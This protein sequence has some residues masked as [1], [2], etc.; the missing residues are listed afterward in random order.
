MD[1]PNRTA[2]PLEDPAER[3]RVIRDA[4]RH[5]RTVQVLLLGGI[6][7]LLALG[8]IFTLMSLAR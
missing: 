6:W 2:K 5:A 7:V 4:V 8:S 1:S 3:E